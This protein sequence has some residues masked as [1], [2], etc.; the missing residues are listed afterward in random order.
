MCFIAS[1]GTLER[2][3]KDTRKQLEGLKME[4]ARMKD[5]MAIVFS[6]AEAL[7]QGG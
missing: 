5:Q 7:R 6:T 3:L 1:V 2:E 4:A